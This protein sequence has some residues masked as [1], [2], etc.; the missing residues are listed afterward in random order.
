[1][2]DDI[3]SFQSRIAPHFLK[4]MDEPT[5]FLYNTIDIQAQ[6][7]EFLIRGQQQQIAGQLAI[8]TR[9][10][11]GEA[12]FQSLEKVQADHA[13]VVARMKSGR[14]I[15]AFIVTGLVIPILVLVFAEKIIHP[16]T[17]AVPDGR[18]SWAR[19]RMDTNESD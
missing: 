8:N 11:A 5:R 15:L 7:N 14:S 13:V 17:P 19:H 12:R 18:S 3:P 4:D 1:M 9:L 2:A 10:A 6:Q 16:A